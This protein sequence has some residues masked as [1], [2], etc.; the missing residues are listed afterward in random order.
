M[1][2]QKRFINEYKLN[3]MEAATLSSEQELAE[4]YEQVVKVS[5]DARLAANW[6]L[7]EILRVLK[8]KKYL[9]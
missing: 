4:Y 6:V 8:K 2:R 7:T 9:Y 5:D 1:R 3:E